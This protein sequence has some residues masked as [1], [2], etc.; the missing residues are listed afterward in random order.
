MN[1]AYDA[2]ILGGGP[3]GATAAVLLAQAGWRVAI[4]EK[5]EF[6]RR[7]VCGEFISATTWPL[8][9]QLG[10]A[11]P[12]LEI[13]G[14]VVR[15]IGIYGGEAMVTAQLLTQP[16]H[17][18]D[19]G[20]AEDSGMALGREHLDTLLLKRAKEAGAEVWQPC[21][22]SAYVAYDD[23]YECTINNRHTHQVHT[24]QSRLIIAAHGSWESAAML[25]QDFRRPPH[26]SDLF[27]FKAHFHG[28]ALPHDLMPLL[29]FPGG[30]GGMVHTDGDRVSLSC[31]I[32]RDQLARCRLSSP[33]AR[34]AEAV[35]THLTSSCKGVELALSA[36]A[37][38]GAWLS[39]GP[40]RTGIRGFGQDGIFAVGN[41]A[42][43]AHP[44]I[45]EGISMAIQ[46]STLLCGQLIAHLQ[47]PSAASCSRHSLEAVR[48]DYAKAWHTNFSRRLRISA[49]FA[50]L[51]M[52]PLT[53]RIATGLL[54]HFPQLLTE[55]ARWSGKTEPLR[56]THPAAVVR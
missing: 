16:A 8:L 9:R 15:R 47:L 51:F 28:S 27:G 56:G 14:P 23:G 20:T 41:A 53:T 32:R 18:Q 45:A 54:Q 26:K 44:I 2:I 50:H 6:P 21:T 13:A 52:R 35:F 33:Q 12:L 34:A 30:Y 38:D 31:C 17:A 43:E 29:A 4:I 7:K 11:Q 48:R 40:L 36:A 49:L 24:L 10:I 55:G 1:A 37:L 22:M 39:V 19:R 46:S 42:A 3:S 5:A 25:T